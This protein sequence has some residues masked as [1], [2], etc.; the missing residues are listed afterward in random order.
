M[1]FDQVLR[2]IGEFGSHQ[3]RV[4]ALLNFSLV[5][6]AFQLLLQV[7]VGA[8]PEWICLKSVSNETCPL[9]KSHCTEIQFTSKFTSIVTEVRF[10]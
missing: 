10:S 4:Y 1:E 6:A 5:P 2:I 7:F 9:N 8:E 3:R